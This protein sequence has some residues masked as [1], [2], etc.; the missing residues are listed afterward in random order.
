[1][2]E[3][4]FIPEEPPVVATARLNTAQVTLAR[5]VRAEGGWVAVMKFAQ[6][7]AANV[8]AS[9]IRRGNA[10]S[11]AHVG[12]FDAKVAQRPGDDESW[13]VYVKFSGEGGE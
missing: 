11:W 10:A 8:A 12:Q 5:K 2:A 4:T 13:F 7:S 6:K 3:Y 9:R 1:M